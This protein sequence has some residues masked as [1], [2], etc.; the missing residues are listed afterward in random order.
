LQGDEVHEVERVLGVEVLGA[1]EGHEQAVSHKLD[2]ELHQ[3]AVHPDELHGQRLRQELLLNLDSLD[4]QLRHSLDIRTVLE[5]V[6]EQAG[7][8]AVEEERN[9]NNRKKELQKRV[10]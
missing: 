9:V 8:V 7:E 10:K 4:D 6:E 5:V 2:V 1:A 3:V